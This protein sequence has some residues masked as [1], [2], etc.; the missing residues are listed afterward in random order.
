MFTEELHYT[1]VYTNAL[2]CIFRLAFTIFLFS[3]SKIKPTLKPTPP[4]LNKLK[5]SYTLDDSLREKLSLTSNILTGSVKTWSNIKDVVDDYLNHSEVWE[6]QPQQFV[7]MLQTSLKTINNI[8]SK[9]SASSTSTTELL[10]KQYCSSLDIFYHHPMIVVDLKLYYQKKELEKRDKDN[11]QQ[12]HIQSNATAS[13]MILEKSRLMEEGSKK[14]LFDEIEDEDELSVLADRKSKDHYGKKVDQ[15][16]KCVSAEEELSIDDISEI[17]KQ[18]EQSLFDAEDP[19]NPNPS[20]S[21]S[22][23]S[24]VKNEKRFDYHAPSKSLISPKKP[25]LSQSNYGDLSDLFEIRLSSGLRTS[26]SSVTQKIFETYRDEQYAN[27]YIK[28]HE[29]AISFLNTV[30]NSDNFMDTRKLWTLPGEAVEDQLQLTQVIKDFF[31]CEK[32]IVEPRRVWLPLRDFRVF[33]INKKLLDGI[34]TNEAETLAVMLESS[35]L[36]YF[37]NKSEATTPHSIDD[38]YKQLKS[39]SDFLKYIIAKYKMGSLKTFMKVQIPCVSVIENYLTLCLTTVHDNSKWKFVEV[40]TCTITT[41]KAEKKPV[42]QS[43]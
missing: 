7:L 29:G 20:M 14:R 23:Y 24:F 15:S 22:Q 1:C 5:G 40:R 43:L 16:M 41:T 19:F 10:L 25:A 36:K 35:G 8:L 31:L 4:N 2:A 30:L 27:A 42:D 33:G 18:Y 26:C 17:S 11:L 38:T 9:Q 6:A 21:K 28:S 12:A 37:L 3:L 34:L 39:T 13:A 32:Q